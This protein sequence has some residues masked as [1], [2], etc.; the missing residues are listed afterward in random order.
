MTRTWRTWRRWARCWRCP[1]SRWT[2][3]SPSSRGTRWGG[4]LCSAFVCLLGGGGGYMGHACLVFCIAPLTPP[5]FRGQPP[6]RQYQIWCDTC[7]LP[8]NFSLGAEDARLRTFGAVVGLVAGA[9]AIALLPA[10]M[11]YRKRCAVRG[12]LWRRANPRST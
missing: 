6:C 11:A 8:R 7:D 4:P 9:A 5:H 2:W 3:T 1:G 10:V 12:C